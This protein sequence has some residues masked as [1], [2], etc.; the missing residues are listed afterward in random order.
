MYL[1]S[2]IADP[3]RLDRLVEIAQSSLLPM[4]EGAILYTIPL[5]LITFV[6]GLILAVLTALAR[7]S[8]IRI[9][10]IIARIYVSA[11][12]GTPLLVQL[13]IIFYGL[14]TIG[15]TI[16][17]FPSAIIGFSLNIGAYASEVIRAAI[18]SIPKGQWEAGYSI[19]MSYTQAM[20]RI[21]LPQAS[22]VS[23][24]PLSNTFISLIKDT[25]LASLI[26]VTEMFRR[27][28][29]IAATNYE[30]L[31]LYSEAAILYWI[32]CFI[33]SIGQG[34]LEARLDRYTEK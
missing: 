12:R 14:P 10:Q 17:P 18:L 30:F 19:G 15:L 26:L 11:I 27:A 16:D 25:S 13:F 24:P 31:L 4:L 9:L 20:R 23:V 1:N 5:T 22:R 6:L 21:I 28:Q 3:E 33:L 32:I 8:K 34:R 7:I 2:I 29:E